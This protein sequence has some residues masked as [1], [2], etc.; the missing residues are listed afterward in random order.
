MSTGAALSDVPP[1]SYCT[2]AEYLRMLVFETPVSIRRANLGVQVYLPGAAPSAAADGV[3][4]FFLPPPDAMP[5]MQFPPRALLR[6]FSPAAFLSYLVAVTLERRIVIVARTVQQLV[7]TAEAALTLLYPFQWE[8]PY[9]PVLPAHLAV[10]CISNPVP[11][12]YGLLTSYAGRVLDDVP[13]SDLAELVVVDAT[14][15]CVDTGGQAYLARRRALSARVVGAGAAAPGGGAATTLRASAGVSNGASPRNAPA[16]PELRLPE[17]LMAEAEAELAELAERANAEAADHSAGQ[18]VTFVTAVDIAIQALCCRLFAVLLYG[19]RSA[20]YFPGMPPQ[21]HPLLT[22]DAY[23]DSKVAALTTAAAVARASKGGS[24]VSARS[25]DAPGMLTSRDFMRAVCQSQMLSRLLQR[26]TSVN[27]RPFHSL[28]SMLSTSPTLA[29]TRKWVLPLGNATYI[30]VVPPPNA[31]LPQLLLWQLGPDGQ[32]LLPA[33]AAAAGEGG[34]AGSGGGGGGGDGGAGGKKKKKDKRPE[35]EQARRWTTGEVAASLHMPAWEEQELEILVAASGKGNNGPHGD[36]VGAPAELDGGAPATDETVALLA[37]ATEAAGSDANPVTGRRSALARSTS[38]ATKRMSRVREAASGVRSR[39]GFFAHKGGQQAAAEAT[40]AAGTPESAEQRVY[41]W[42]RDA[43]VVGA[44][45]AHTTSIHGIPWSEDDDALVATLSSPAVRAAFVRVLQTQVLLSAGLTAP[46]AGAVPGALVQLQPLLGLGVSAHTLTH[47]PASRTGA[48]APNSALLP[49]STAAAGSTA[50]VAATGATTTPWKGPSGSSTARTLLVQYVPLTRFLR[51][52]AMCAALLSDAVE[53]KDYTA[54]AA[55]LQVSYFYYTEPQ[56]DRDAAAAISAATAAAPGAAPRNGRNTAWTA[57]RQYLNQELAAEPMWHKLEFW[58]AYVAGAVAVEEQ[59]IRLLHLEA[60]KHASATAGGAGRLPAGG[61]TPHAESTDGGDGGVASGAASGGTTNLSYQYNLLQ[62][63]LSP[64]IQAGLGPLEIGSFVSSASASLDI[65][66]LEERT[67][68]SLVDHLVAAETNSGTANTAAPSTLGAYMPFRHGE[69]AEMMGKAPGSAQRGATSASQA[70]G[71]PVPPAAAAAVGTGTAAAGAAG[72]STVAVGAP[73]ASGGSVPAGTG[74]AASA[75]ALGAAVAGVGSTSTTAA[76]SGGVPG[77]GSPT[78]PVDVAPTIDVAVSPNP[79]DV[80]VLPAPAAAGDGA[81]AAGQPA[82]RLAT[83]DPAAPWFPMPPPVP[84]QPWSNLTPADAEAQARELVNARRNPPV[85]DANVLALLQKPKGRNTKPAASQV[86]S[87]NVTAETQAPGGISAAPPA[88]GGGSGGAPAEQ[89]NTAASVVPA[90]TTVPASVSGAGG[91][92]SKAKKGMQI[93]KAFGSAVGLSVIGSS[94]AAPVPNIA[95]TAIPVGA[96]PV[97]G[98]GSPI[99]SS[100]TVGNATSVTVSL[101]NGLL[102]AVLYALTNTHVALQARSGQATATAVHMSCLAFRGHAPGAAITSMVHSA[103]DGRVVTGGNDGRVV[104][105][106]MFHRTHVHSYQ[107]HAAAV[108][109]V[110]VCGDVVLSASQDGTVRIS[111]FARLPP[112]GMPAV[113]ADAPGGPGKDARDNAGGAS[114]AEDEG[115]EGDE[116]EGDVDGAQHGGMAAAGGAGMDSAQYLADDGGEERGG[117]GGGGGSGGG[118]GGGGSLWGGITLPLPVPNLFRGS[119]GDHKFMSAIRLKGHSGPVTAVDAWER[120][121]EVKRTWFRRKKATDASVRTLPSTSNYIVVSGGSDGTIRTW[122]ARWQVA[123]SG[124]ASGTALHLATY[125]NLHK[126]G[127]IIEQVKLSVDGRLCVSAGRDGRIGVVDVATGK[128]WVMMM[129]S[130]SRGLFSW[131]SGT[132]EPLDPVL[133]PTGLPLVRCSI[134]VV[135][136]PVT[137]TSAG[138]DGT[139]RVWDLRTGSVAAAF[140][141]G[142][143]IWD[144]VTVPAHGGGVRQLNASGELAAP[145]SALGDAYLITAHDDGVIR[146][147]DARMSHAPMALFTGHTH[148]VTTLSVDGDKVVSGSTDASVRL[149]DAR[150]GLSVRCDGHMAT[151]SGTAVSDDYM[152]SASWDGSLACW[153]PTT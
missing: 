20:T 112:M 11:F 53:A 114:G 15:G 55:L 38:K 43:L 136:R 99:T 6:V 2:L 93:V 135:R 14:T 41:A 52:S 60:E 130:S 134:D 95:T 118:G 111:S 87:R 127:S 21:L 29:E 18:G 8:L 72:S 35:A 116:G 74:A 89:S 149:W 132:K 13:E 101:D 153:Y 123:K 45:P 128:T 110:Q 37:A 4:T 30:L 106:D 150:T 64:M 147:W 117:G 137:V 54:A 73:A 139:A 69:A 120:P 59:Q 100:Q 88:T 67:I 10:D 152:V 34:Q 98:A 57:R 133:T 19:Y 91:A 109:M 96:P 148:A 102:D 1:P 131:G 47:T 9:I 58:Q 42:L 146:K 107:D 62:T 82:S 142:I 80:V 83:A 48:S 119:R 79:A 22:Q 90:V 16:D 24:A 5:H 97:G 86:I 39:L 138:M 145:P 122:A 49:A 125:S 25:P 141:S 68:L 3:C 108:T 104:L 84:A 126:A 143:P 144:F 81:G 63:L 78:G 51:L 40:D 75:A 23:I 66:L 105:W 65:S 76:T 103:E 28:T 121:E 94:F 31:Q 124:K 71:S 113:G 7:E 70:A 26:H 27:L 151:V 46:L 36:D 12:I 33:A 140:P 61:G 77:V 56:R 92:S 17:P 32:R 50:T 129:P 44:L 115:D 85:P